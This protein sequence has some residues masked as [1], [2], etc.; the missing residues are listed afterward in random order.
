MV[1]TDLTF[2]LWSSEGKI[3]PQSYLRAPVPWQVQVEAVQQ[4]WPENFKRPMIGRS[5]SPRPLPSSASSGSQSARTQKLHLGLVA[6]TINSRMATKMATVASVTYLKCDTESAINS[7]F[8]P[9]HSS[10]ASFSPPE[11]D[12]P[13][14]VEEGRSSASVGAGADAR[15][16]A[17]ILLS[18]HAKDGDI[19]HAH[20][21]A[22]SFEPYVHTMIHICLP[23]QETP[24][25][26]N[27]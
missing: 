20:D 4:M 11:R 2:S 3:G 13:R 16:S 27:Q 23:M 25:C 14:Q 15:G 9:P 10:L 18:L 7:I 26:L 8:I 24:V 19:S 22:L 1:F 17:R 5:K 6:G 21:A 12:E